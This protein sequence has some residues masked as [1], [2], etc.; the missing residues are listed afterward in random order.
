MFHECLKAQRRGL[1][2]WPKTLPP[3]LFYDDAGSLLY[4]RITEL[5]EYYLTRA[6]AAILRTHSDRIVERLTDGTLALR[7][8]PLS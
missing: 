6:E 8:H 2:G 5:P 1:S 3:H 4:E 7:H